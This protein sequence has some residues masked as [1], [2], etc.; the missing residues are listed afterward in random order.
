MYTHTCTEAHMF[1]RILSQAHMHTHTHTHTHTY[2]QTH[3]FVLLFH[4]WAEGCTPSFRG[5]CATRVF[6]FR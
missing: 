1:K 2:S 6:I 3:L 5:G 4:V